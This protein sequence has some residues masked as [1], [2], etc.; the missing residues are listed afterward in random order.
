[1]EER[2]CHGNFRCLGVTGRVQPPSAWYDGKS[3]E[4]E[5]ERD[6]LGNGRAV[7]R[8]GKR[9]EL[10]KVFKSGILILMNFTHFS[11][12]FVVKITILGY[13][14]IDSQK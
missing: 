11:R 6:K 14:Y 7:F 9:G 4:K 2:D 12:G 1:M 3:L 13:K 5:G 8:Y 10:T